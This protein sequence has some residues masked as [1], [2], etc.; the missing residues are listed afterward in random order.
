MNGVLGF[1][2]SFRQPDSSSSRSNGSSKSKVIALRNSPKIL[3]QMN[4]TQILKPAAHLPDQSILFRISEAFQ[5]TM[6]RVTN[7]IQRLKPVALSKI[8]E[9][10]Q[11][12]MHHA[13]LLKK[14]LALTVAIAVANLFA[15]YVGYKYF[16]PQ[17]PIPS[18]FTLPSL[19]EIG[20]TEVTVGSLS[21]SALLSIPI[22]GSCVFTKT[23]AVDLSPAGDGT[24]GEDLPPAG[25]GTH[26]GNLPPADEDVAWT[27]I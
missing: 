25:D 1:L 11:S 2:S 8:A 22:I 10:S 24:H 3:N 14:R 26:G 12:T 6:H 5:A 18:P 7:A 15:I 20:T 17:T 23:H 19:P 27:G 13:L 4:A 9:A 16:S 21:I